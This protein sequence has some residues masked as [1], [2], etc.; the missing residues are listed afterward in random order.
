MILVS[1]RKDTVRETPALVTV[2][3]REQLDRLKPRNILALQ[4]FV[5]VN[6]VLKLVKFRFLSLINGQLI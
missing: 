4:A 3:T 2:Y 6:F 5:G 1:K